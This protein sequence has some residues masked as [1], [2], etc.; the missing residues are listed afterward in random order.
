MGNFYFKD[1]AVYKDNTLFVQQKVVDTDISLTLDVPS[2]TYYQ[3]INH[4]QNTLKVIPYARV[5]EGGKLIT[6]SPHMEYGDFSGS[7]ESNYVT[8][9]FDQDYTDPD[10]TIELV[11]R[12]G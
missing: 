2:S 4:A 9:W 6:M 5:K 3:V 8:L 10:D 12:R 11:I 7:D 1:G